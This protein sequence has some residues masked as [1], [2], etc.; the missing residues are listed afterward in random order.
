VS[1][2]I[3]DRSLVAALEGIKQEAKM[4]KI[5]GAFPLE[6]PDPTQHSSSH[7]GS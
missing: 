4:L 6:R 7:Q 2:H 5:L 1:G 3:T